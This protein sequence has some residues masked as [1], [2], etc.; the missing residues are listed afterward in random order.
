MNFQV[1]LSRQRD[2]LSTLKGLITLIRDPE[3][4]DSVYDIEDGL[5]HIE[6]T[7]LAVDHAK[8]QPG[9]AQL[10]AERYIAPAPDI[11]GL[12]QLPAESLGYAY[13]S[14]ITKSGFDPNFYR[15]E[16]IDDDISYYFMR[17][18]QT[19]DIWH[20][21]T[22]FGVDVNGELGLKAFELAQVRRPL[23]AML[24]AGGIV[25]TMLRT[26][27]AMTALLEQIALGYRLGNQA[28]PLFA[29]KWE[30]DWQKPLAEWRT[31]LGLEVA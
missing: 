25:E 14:Y 2:I 8:A 16:S 3:Q 13:A 19:H 22:Q 9:V 20:I 26:P 18:R 4:T 30:E 24:L 21:V 1:L 10:F 15:K 11:P 31:Q 6:A 28:Q 7:Q 5:R 29:Q 27:E 23:A 17:M 12:L